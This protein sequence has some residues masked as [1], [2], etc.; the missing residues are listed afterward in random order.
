[1]KI[2]IRDISEEGLEV[3][4]ELTAEYIGLTKKD[5]L[6]FISPLKVH[7]VFHRYDTVVIGS[8]T[9]SGRFE[10]F[11]YRS[12]EKVERDWV[13]KFQIDFPVTK[14]TEYLEVDDDLRQE[15]FVQVP[16]RVLSDVEMEKEKNNPVKEPEPVENINTS[17]FQGPTHRPFEKLKDFD[18]T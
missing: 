7:A 15:V 5:P 16:L 9:V 6:F 11:C 4:G 14:G 2:L 1:M 18:N 13:S 8:F 3:D 12:L 10:S 17:K